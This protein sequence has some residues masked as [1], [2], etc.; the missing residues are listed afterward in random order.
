MTQKASMIISLI[1]RP[2]VGKS[3]LFNVLMPRSQRAITFNAPGVTRD[4]HYG[5]TTLEQPGGDS[6]LEAILVDTGGLFLEQRPRPLFAE[7]PTLAKEAKKQWQLDHF[8][9][10]MAEQG[11]IAIGESDLV[12]LVL[13]GRE[14][15]LPADLEICQ[16]LRTQ[17]KAF[18]AVV[19]KFDSPKQEGDEAPFYQLGVEELFLVSAAHGR[20]IDGLRG[21]I[22]G[23][24]QNWEKHQ[25]S[26]FFS[27][28]MIS[29][30]SVVAKVAIIGGPNAGKSTLLNQLL[31]APRALVSPVAGTTI[32]PVD[33]ILSL[34]FGADVRLLTPK[35][36]GEI[37]EFEEIVDLDLE[38]EIVEEQGPTDASPLTEPDVSDLVII[39]ANNVDEVTE[40]TWRSIHLVDTAGIRRKNQVQGVV[41]TQ[42]VY[43][44]LHA[45]SV[46][47]VVIYLID[48]VK[49]IS[50][51]DRRLID[52]VLEKGKSIIITLNKM[53]L[54]Q[55][56]QGSNFRQREVLAEL[57]ADLPWCEFCDLVMISAHKGNNLGHLLQ[58]LKKT[59]LVR[60]QKISTGELNRICQG[61]F[62]R[63]P[64]LVD[65]AHQ[66]E[67][68][69]KYVAMIKSAPPTFLMFVN[70][71]QSIPAN[72]RRYLVNALRK[73]L[74]LAN[75]P[76]HLI[77]R[78]GV[79]LERKAQKITSLK[80]S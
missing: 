69:L 15:L 44:A 22:W 8:F 42:A 78:A 48:G 72:Y 75:T 79:D 17:K 23:F 28:P 51:Q 66:K 32:D 5:F 62:A 21:G 18:L 11:K 31:Q 68:K 50:H 73:I 20:G 14:G 46:A 37:Q 29:P 76:V 60:H 64:I 3:S 59:I 54:I 65:K 24:Y 52:I 33:G 55:A 2:N 38:E 19:N 7:H 26:H 74:D 4:R 67:L 27:G 47:D 43:R 58:I 36:I 80:H 13:D 56:G 45:I 61:L 77:F 39:P 49:G 16:Y 25:T 30:D 40:D 63:H 35:S 1:G 53:D 57:A 34:D 12:L 70:R 10:L 9:N 71:S 6:S 41:E